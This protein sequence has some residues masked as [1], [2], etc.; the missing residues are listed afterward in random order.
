M[1][2]AIWDHAWPGGGNGCRRAEATILDPL[3]LAHTGHNVGMDWNLIFCEVRAYR[4]ATIKLK[5]LM[6][7]L[8]KT[9]KTLYT[10]MLM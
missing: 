5:F 6:H 1:S 2:N 3:F 4:G 7:F 10:L 9:K 8:C